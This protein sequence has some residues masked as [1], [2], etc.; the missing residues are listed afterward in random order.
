MQNQKKGKCKHVKFIVLELI[1]GGQLFDF[2]ALG[3]RLSE[4]TARYF[5]QQMIE[6]I[7]FMHEKGL[8]HRDL[9]PEN[10]LLD[11][12]YVLKVTD[13][14][15]AAPV[16][17]RDNTGLLKTQLGTMNYMAPEIILGGS[18]EGSII[19]LFA[20]GIILFVMLTRR[21]PFVSANPK[22]ETS[23]YRLLAV[24]QGAVFWQLHAQA[25]NGEDIYSA[26]FKDL[27][28]K[29]MTLKPSKRLSIEEIK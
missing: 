4:A 14:G 3:G 7:G 28:E 10:L 11:Q 21:P 15:F 1:G 19:D 13:F 22:D 20:A 9:K 6:V 24:G 2:V 23:A 25:E 17:G 12:N 8:A 29:M 18:Y 5:F 26:E 27:F 16:A